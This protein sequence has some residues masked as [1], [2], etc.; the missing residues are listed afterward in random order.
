M[1]HP[2][3]SVN[4]FSLLI[5]QHWAEN[6]KRYALSILAIA[7]LLIAWFICGMLIE[8]ENPMSGGAQEM[9]FFLMLFATGT[10]Y[11]GYYFRDLSSR[12]KGSNFM[13]VPASV[14]EKFLC[15][16]LYTVVLF[17]LSYTVIFYLVDLCMVSLSNNIH[18]VKET[19][20]ATV[21]NIFETVL[22]R[23]RDE[24]TVRSLFLFF[25][26]QSLFLLGSVY[27]RKYTFLKTAVIGFALFFVIFCVLYFFYGRHWHE[28]NDNGRYLHLFPEWA[29]QPFRLIVMY[30]ATPLIWIITYYRLK[31]K[32]V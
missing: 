13:L 10:F 1:M 8:D 20:N 32:Q 24:S 25:V 29:E 15:A 7:G 17:F 28:D 18:N 30:L 6:K 27:F 19:G 4:R 22:I 16:L 31:A 21:A 2:F 12:D 23:F 14:F 11:A 3:F 9:I 5:A 26:I